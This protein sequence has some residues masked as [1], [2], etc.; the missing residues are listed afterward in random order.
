ME[1]LPKKRADQVKAIEKMEALTLSAS[2]V[3][4]GGV[5]YLGAAGLALKVLYDEDAL[6]EEAVIAW[7]QAQ[8]AAAA[9]DPDM[10]A[11]FLGR[12]RNLSSSGS[13]RRR[14]RRRRATDRRALRGRRAEPKLFPIQTKNAP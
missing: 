1:T 7:G 9:L 8:E 10:D 13:R 3:A 12:R 5:R 2:L 6:S 14:R 4:D 11:R